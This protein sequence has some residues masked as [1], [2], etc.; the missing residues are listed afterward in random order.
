MNELKK[1]VAKERKYLLQ[2]Y[3]RPDDFL[4]VKG[5]GCLLWDIH[6]KPYLDFVSGI[7][8]NSLGHRNPA[9]LKAITGHL[10]KFIHI[11]NLYHYQLHAEVAELLVKHS[12]LDRVFFCNSGTEANEAAIKFARRTAI[13]NHGQKKIDIITF[14]NGFH[15]RTYGALSATAQEKYRKDFGPMLLGFK[16]ID[17]NDISQLEKAITR[18]TAAV[19]IEL[20]QGEGGGH[21]ITAAY[22]RKLSALCRKYDVL[23]IV[24]EIQT[25]LGR[26]GTF[27]FSEQFP[28]KPDIVTLAKPLGGGLPL[29]AVLMTQAVADH[30]AP[31]D[32]GTTF[33]GNPVACAAAKTV[34]S[35]VLKKGFLASVRKKGM[36]LRELLE[37]TGSSRVK[38][39][40]GKG[41]WLCAEMDGQSAE[42]INACRKKGL[43]VCRAGAEGIRFLPP[44]TVTEREIRRAGAIFKSVL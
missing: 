13:R 14:N 18:N 7:A 6:N 10:T 37:T 19:L 29:G 9:L 30:L 35:T 11:S 5:K 28:I 8:V 36:L 25:G 16:H 41:L 4:P 39:V 22:A 32:H 40:R 17:F 20:L 12:S 42:I 2:N 23:L 1:E 31:G 27:L 34:L 21:T 3:T 43:L 24:D 33:G 26:L 15:G 44:L 38:S